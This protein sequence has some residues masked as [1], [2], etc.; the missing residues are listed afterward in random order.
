MENYE[1]SSEEL[2]A[3]KTLFESCDTEKRGKIL[4]NQL[5][6]LLAK[7]KKNQA[8]ITRITEA[9]SKVADE[10]DGKLRFKEILSILEKQEISVHVP[11]EGSDPKVIE[12]LRILE[13]YRVKCEEEGNYMEAGRAHKQLGVLRKQEEKRQQ[14]VVKARQISERQDVQLGHNMQFNEFNNAW[15]K[16]MEEYDNMAQMY[17]QQMTERHAIVLLDFQK[18]LRQELASK[19][20]KWSREL[21]E[22]RRKQHIYARNKNYAEAQK[23]KKV[24]DK[25]ED[26]ERRDL[27]QEQAIVFAKRE[28]KFRKQQQTELQALLK[29]I[30]CRRKEHIK[31]RNLDSKRLLQRNK[32]V[33]SVLESKQNIESQRVF[34]TIKKTLQNNSAI[35]F[36]ESKLLNQSGPSNPQATGTGTN[37]SN[38]V[39]QFKSSVLPSVDANGNDNYLN[40]SYFD[41]SIEK[42]QYPIRESGEDR[43][44]EGEDREGGEDQVYAEQNDATFPDFINDLGPRLGGLSEDE[45]EQ[46]D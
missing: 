11:F 26:K 38:S 29:R 44:G 35:S 12:F 2:A 42:R 43:E 21:L 19:P 31:Q 18:S 10:N 3:I 4:I 24:C 6:G 13:E 25:C 34:E 8:E 41:D 23:L 20:P 16:Y 39:S 33:Q 45:D 1:Y 32:N 15:D 17:I 46:Y 30:E 37:N 5:P 36:S 7:L 22:Q 9:A 27:E 28:V 14:K 40:S